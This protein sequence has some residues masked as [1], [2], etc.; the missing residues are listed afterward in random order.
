MSL[1]S[2]DHNMLPNTLENEEAYDFYD[3]S[4]S[5]FRTYGLMKDTDGIFRRI[6]DGV[7]KTVSEGVRYTNEY[8]AGGRFVFRTNAKKLAIKTSMPRMEFQRVVNFMN[9][10]GVDLYKYENGKQTLLRSIVPDADI[11]TGGFSAEA[12]LYDDT[13]KDIVLYTSC[14]ATLKDIFIGVPKGCFIREAENDYS[15]KRRLVIG[16]TRFKEAFLVHNCTKNL[17]IR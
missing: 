11:T 16:I 8:T 2:F 3:A 9:C 13:E 5:P 17:D 1:A 7:A 6:P 15:H 4:K 10:S 14:H 12:D